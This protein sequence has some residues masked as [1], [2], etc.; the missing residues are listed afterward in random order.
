MRGLRGLESTVLCDPRQNEFRHGEGISIPASTGSMTADPALDFK[1][2]TVIVSNMIWG[3]EQGG[4]LSEG[5]TI[6]HFYFLDIQP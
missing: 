6:Q 1:F 2:I 4:L 3:G 5:E